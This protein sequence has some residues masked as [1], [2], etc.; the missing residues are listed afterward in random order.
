[1]GRL[2][3]LVEENSGRVS[4][5]VEG[6]PAKEQRVTEFG[7]L[8]ERVEVLEQDNRRI[9]DA[10]DVVKRGVWPAVAGGS[11]NAQQD[12]TNPERDLRS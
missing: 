1:V 10:N 8:R 5:G 2:E 12:L 11:G 4:T 3:A 6:L 9:S 7:G